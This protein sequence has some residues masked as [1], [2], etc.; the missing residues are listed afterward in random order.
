MN[1][2]NTMPRFTT[3]VNHHILKPHVTDLSALEWGRRNGFADIRLPAENILNEPGQI[4]SP[5]KFAE[6]IEPEENLLDI[7][8]DLETGRYYHSEKDAA[9]DAIRIFLQIANPKAEWNLPQSWGFWFH[10]K[11]EFNDIWLSPE[12]IE[13][14][15]SWRNS[16]P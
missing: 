8:F 15:I 14:K 3:I 7:E 1:W 16:L 4:A 9:N 12:N 11:G 2:R 10:C 5:F 6:S 13:Q